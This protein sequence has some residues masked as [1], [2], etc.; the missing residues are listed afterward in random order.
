LI[1][2]RKKLRTQKSFFSFIREYRILQINFLEVFT[3]WK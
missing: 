1:M 2:Q 3:K